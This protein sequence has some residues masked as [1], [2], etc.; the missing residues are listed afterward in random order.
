MKRLK[1][2]TGIIL[3]IVLV[4]GCATVK[5]YSDAGLNNETGLRY[6]TL[7]PY[8][9]VEYLANKDNTIKTTVVYLP[10][11]S[12]PQYMKI[13]SGMGSSELKMSFANSSLESYGVATDSKIPESFEAFAA[14]LSKSAYATAPWSHMEWPPTQRYPRVLRRLRP[15]SPRAPMPLRLLRAPRPSNPQTRKNCLWIQELRSGCLRS[16]P[17]QPAPA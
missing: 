10:D 15:C 7:K 1:L 11:L 17:N 12:S 14:M 8:L 5:V 6:Y 13:R 4:S 16:L 9:L 3:A 2:I